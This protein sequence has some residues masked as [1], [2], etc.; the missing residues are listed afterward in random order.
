MKN[1][2]IVKYFILYVFILTVISFIFSYS[3]ISVISDKFN[4]SILD[5]VMVINDSEY[6][7]EYYV[8]DL[9]ITSYS[10]YSE[11]IQKDKFGELLFANDGIVYNRK[12][13][14]GKQSFV[15]DYSWLSSNTFSK[16]EI[17]K[18][19][20][21]HKL[22]MIIRTMYLTGG[23]THLILLG[24]LLIIILKLISPTLIFLITSIYTYIKFKELQTIVNSSSNSIKFFELYRGLILTKITN[25]VKQSKFLLLFT[26][27][28]AYLTVYLFI[29]KGNLNLVYTLS[30]NII[31]VYV[32]LLL[33]IL[34]YFLFQTIIDSETKKLIDELNIFLK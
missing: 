26:F 28:Y 33:F 4:D 11:A 16:K 6:N 31:F 9:L 1:T 15:I 14:I 17:I 19:L 29:L 22:L 13:P 2:F 7:K 21:N 25:K 20:K 5:D 12:T 3:F 23:F 32:G 10:N 18:Y 27:S 34:S 30:L 24:L 8:N